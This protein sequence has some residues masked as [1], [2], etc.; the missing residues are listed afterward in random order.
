MAGRPQVNENMKNALRSM[1][2]AR[3]KGFTLIELLVVIGIMGTLITILLPN[4]IG[5]RQRSRDAK[6]RL[7][8]EQISSA[9]EQ[10]RSVAGTYPGSLTL[11]CDADKE[12]LTYTD[13][14]TDPDT[15]TTFLTTIPQDPGCSTYIYTNPLLTSTDYTL[16]AYLEASTS[17]TSITSDCGENNCNYCK[18]PYGT[19]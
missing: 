12:T 14:S 9:L 16:C 4:F 15:V 8:I 13:T 3:G 6:R 19:K 1:P 18:G 2:Q 17:T 5:G 7:D 11:N 10:Y